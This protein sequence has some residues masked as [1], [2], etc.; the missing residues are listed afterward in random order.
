[1]SR[2][3]PKLLLALA[4]AGLTWLA[5][6]AAVSWWPR[7]SEQ[8]EAGHG[9]SKIGNRGDSSAATGE[10]PAAPNR[11][12]PP[13]AVQHQGT[14]IFPPSSFV[15]WPVGPDVVSRYFEI[16]T[17]LTEFD[18][19]SYFRHRG[20]I[21]SPRKWGEHPEQRW[22]LRT[23]SLGMRMDREPA[24]TPPDLRVLVVGDSHTDGVCNNAE[25]YPALLEAALT[26]PGRSAEVLNAAKGGHSFYNYL[27][28]LERFLPL[29][30]DVLVVCVYGGNDF[31]ELLTWHHYFHQTERP[32]GAALYREAIAAAQAVAKPALSQAGVAVKYFKTQPSQIEAALQTARDLT[33]EIAIT[34]QRFGV[35]PVFCY[36]P[37]VS[38][39]Q[40]EQYEPVLEQLTTALEVERSD[41]EVLDHIADSWLAYARAS[42]LDVLDLRTAFRASAEPLYWEHDHHISLAGQA[43]VAS[44]L[45]QRMREVWPADAERVRRAPQP[46]RRD[47]GEHAFARRSPGAYRPGVTASLDRRH[48]PPQ[49][50]ARVHPLIDGEVYDEHAL[51]RHGPHLDQ[52][53]VLE[54]HPAGGWHLRTNSLGLRM[55]AEVRDDA[56]D[57]RILVTGDGNADGVCDNADGFPSLLA[58]VLAAEHPGTSV[59]AL[60]AGKGGYSFYN[61]LG[62]LERFLP[63]APDVFVMLV[64]GGN[65]FFEVLELQSF[66]GGQARI[67]HS[68]EYWHLVEAALEVAPESLSQFFNP[69]KYFA[70]HRAQVAAAAWAAGAVT[71]EIRR[72]C[73]REGIELVVVYLPPACDVEWERLRPR[74]EPVRELLELPV[75]RMGTLD[76]L[77]GAYLDEVRARGVRVIDLRSVFALHPGPFFWP[78]DL[79]MNLDAQRL[80]AAQ[81]A[82]VCGRL[83]I[84]GDR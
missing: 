51:F 27:G 32:P 12:L 21:E 59:E 77:A 80:L 40:W 43:L 11:G 17:A 49:A 76:V 29:A 69:L 22:V 62:T 47:D 30:P 52:T 37:A 63:L 61:Y 28:T 45:E 41:F 42:G 16:D 65:D 74:L 33:A 7:T 36:L 60:N 79:H 73:E 84:F 55:D 39:V 72:T 83:P 56:P 24:S 20:G 54:A 10:F 1:M 38:Q 26:R 31:E 14:P 3:L 78:E 44:E 8:G 57:V 58:A 5:V 2:L 19:Y 35:R 13:L 18:P 75:E 67:D 53:R 34:C 25:G 81:L 70:E 4:S 9:G 66:F 64:Y 68:E 71:E 48:L 82:E 50:A 6:W 15:R 46:R 23:N